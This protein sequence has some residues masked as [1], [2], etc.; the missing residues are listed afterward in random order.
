MS[1]QEATPRPLVLG[2]TGGIASGKSTIAGMLERLGACRVSAD[3]IAREL[4]SPG[5]LVTRAVI[6]HFGQGVAAEGSQ[7]AEV[8]RKRLAKLIFNNP[9]ARRELGA[10]MHPPIRER[11]TSQIEAFRN[12]PSCLL[13][14][15]E[16]PLLY[17]NGLEGMVDRVLVAKCPENIQVRRLRDRQPWLSEEDALRQIRAQMPLEEKVA[18]AD[19]VIETDRALESVEAAAAAL[20]GRFAKKSSTKP[21]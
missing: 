16:I 2:I 11:M 4:L 6:A 21:E 1:D 3:E 19:E 9:D 13:I 12:D 7:S 17:E 10:I 15:A 8:D 20:L 18:R 5:S 14:A